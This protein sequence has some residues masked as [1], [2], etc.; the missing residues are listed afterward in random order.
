MG[1]T[2]P[3]FERCCDPPSRGPPKVAL[4]RDG[5][6]S[7]AGTRSPRNQR[8]ATNDTGFETSVMRVERAVTS[9]VRTTA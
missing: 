1:I 9:P 8:A 4:A 6:R 7:S 5:T 2:I 3:I